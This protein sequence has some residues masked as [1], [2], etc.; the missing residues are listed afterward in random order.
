MLVAPNNEPAVW[1][2]SDFFERMHFL[3][4]TKKQSL[5]FMPFDFFVAILREIQ[6]LKYFINFDKNSQN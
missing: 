2:L 5:I 6:N 4:L 3:V 1:A